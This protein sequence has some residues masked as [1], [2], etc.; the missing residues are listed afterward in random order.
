MITIYCD[1]L[2]LPNPGGHATWGFAAFSG[3][4]SGQEGAARPEPLSAQRGYL[5]QNQATSNN[6]AEYTAVHKALEWLRDTPDVALTEVMLCTDSKL[7]V[8]QINGIWGCNI[9]KTRR[10]RTMAKDLI[11]ECARSGILVKIHWV[12]GDPDNWVAD[13]QTMIA[14]AEALG[15]P[16]AD[17]YVK[18]RAEY[19]ARPA[20]AG[21]PH[22]KR[23][24]HFGRFSDDY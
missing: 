14:F 19:T 15:V 1:G 2:C 20:R 13:Q 4:V 11:A 9:E 21:K 12:R 16:L 7:V 17:A 18:R 22:F 5:G 23:R 10:W 3:K 8:N 24:R 6:L